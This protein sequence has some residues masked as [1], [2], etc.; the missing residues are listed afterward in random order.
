[1]SIVSALPRELYPRDACVGLRAA[2]DLH[3]GTA[4][5]LM[6]LSQ[7]AYETEEPAKVASVLADWGLEGRPI[8]A[9]PG[10]TGLGSSV[11]GIG[12]RGRTATVVAV[13]GTD[14]LV[15]GDFITDLAINLSPDGIHTGFRAAA[16][17]LMPAI[18]AV[19]GDAATPVLVAGH[20]LGGAV[21]AVIAQRLAAAAGRAPVAVYTYGMPRP[22]GAAFMAAYGDDLGMRTFRLVHGDDAIAAVPPSE[23]G[24][25]HVGRLLKA[26]SGGRFE[27]ARLSAEFLPLEPPFLARKPADALSW[28]R[29]LLPPIVPATVR[30]DRVGRLLAH[31]PPSFA[32]HFPDRYLAALDRSV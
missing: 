29:G 28:V 26:P 18:L 31:V 27:A 21:A 13:A 5:A 9:P 11:R 22:G 32:D 7:L 16:D 19:V 14:P 8:A 6:W 20:S 1:M 17:L 4:R 23:I 25:R 12:A 24:Y 2:A 3:L 15:P 10:T 30:R